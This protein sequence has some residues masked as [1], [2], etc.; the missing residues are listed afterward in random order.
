MNGTTSTAFAQQ[1]DAYLAHW[2][3][4][5]RGYRQEQWLLQKVLRELPA[6]GYDDLSAA[7]FARWFDGRKHCHPNSRRSWAR[8]IRHFCVFRRRSDPSCFVP[9]PELICRGQPYVTPVIV[10]DRCVARMLDAADALE[11]SPKSPLRPATMR[12]AVVLLYTTGLRLGELRRLELRDIEDDG[13]ALRVRESK[14]HRTRVLPLSASVAAELRAYVQRRSDAGFDNRPT[15]PLL[16]VRVRR[17]GR[18]G[19]YSMSGLQQGLKVLLRGATVAAG[20]PRPPRNHDLRHSYALQ[21]LARGYRQ[22]ADVQAQL[23]KLAMYMGHVSIQSTAYYLRWTDEIA[24][25]ASQRF[26]RHFGTAIGGQP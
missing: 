14:F 13:T 26:E 11:P 21:V 23:P 17:R 7:S 9:G 6:L 10:D 25:L 2:R 3:A 19:A 22:G 15:T 1:I 8:L 18:T 20:K 4:L 24:S 5:G 16:C 12:L